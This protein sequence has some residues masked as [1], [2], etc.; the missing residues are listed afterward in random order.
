M[1]DK[2]PAIGRII[3]LKRDRHT[4]CGH[5]AG[6]G[7]IITR[8]P[9]MQIYFKDKNGR[10]TFAR[11]FVAICDTEEEAQSIL[12]LS[13]ESSNAYKAWEEKYKVALSK[14]VNERVD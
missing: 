10:E 4:Y 2:N 9:K 6:Y 13:Q 14:L 7:G 12:D 8:E 11:N 1:I 5:F 3:I